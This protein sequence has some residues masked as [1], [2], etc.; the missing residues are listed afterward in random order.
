VTR[1]RA[2][3][4]HAPG[5][6]RVEDVPDPVVASPTDAVVQVLRAGTCGSDL[7]SYRGH[8]PQL[9][10][11]R[12]SGHEFMGVVEDVGSEATSLRRGQL[13][14]AP[15]YFS[16]GTCEFCR[17]GLT[18]ACTQIDGWG[19][20]NDGGQG[21]AVRVQVLLR[22]VPMAPRRVLALSAAGVAEVAPAL[23]HWLRVAVPLLAATGRG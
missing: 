19:G 22:P 20:A 3:V 4:Y 16:D 2:A 23:V 9:P 14:L 11:G 15:F 5:D 6:I 13:V 18:S 1:V 7:W 8:Y 10:S 17:A 12:R 21:E